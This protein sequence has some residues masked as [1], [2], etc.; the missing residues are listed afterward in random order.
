M[1]RKRSNQEYADIVL[2]ILYTKDIGVRVRGMD[3]LL[4]LA[5]SK[6]DNADERTLMNIVGSSEGLLGQGLVDCK[7]LEGNGTGIVAIRN[8]EL[9]N[10]GREYVSRN[11]PSSKMHALLGWVT[12]N[13]LGA[14][15]STAVGMLVGWFLRGLIRP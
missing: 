3:D 9:T 5:K 11:L 15:I 6:L 12:T 10:A 14:S 4:R 2:R 1:T 13:I 8:I 7:T